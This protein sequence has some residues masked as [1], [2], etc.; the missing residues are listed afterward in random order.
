MRSNRHTFLGNWIALGEDVNDRN[1][2]YFRKRF[3][4]GKRV[5]TEK[6]TEKAELFITGMGLFTVRIN[7]EFPDDTVLNPGETQYS[8]TM[9]YRRFDVSS[10]IHKGENEI[11]VTLGNGFYNENSGV[12]NWEK[13]AWRKS[14][15]MI[16][17]LMLDDTCVLTSDLSWECTNEG[18]I[19]ENSIYLGEE[20][21]T[22]RSL[23]AAAWRTPIAVPAPD[24]RFK[25]QGEPFIRRTHA[26]APVSKRVL[27]DGKQI[28]EAPAMMT[29]WAAIR[30]R[31]PQG[32][33]IVITYG[34]TLKKDGSVVFTGNGE[35][36]NHDWW[37]QGVLQ[38][39]RFISNG[40]ETVFE[41]MFNYKGFRYVQVENCSSEICLEDV[42]LYQVANDIPVRASFSCSD[43]MLN[44]MH[45]TMVRTLVNNFQFKPTD[46]PVW[47][48]NGWLGD[49]NCALE[50]MFF[51]FDMSRY[52]AM[53]LD[54]MKDCMEEFGSVPVMV[55]SANWSVG[56]MPVWSSLFV[57][58]AKA[59][60][61]FCGET[62]KVEELYPALKAY[63]ELN[64]REV[65]ENGWIYAKPVLSDWVSPMGDPALGIIP[66]PPEG[67]KVLA[68]AYVYALLQA[69]AEI[70]GELK[71]N[72]E[73]SLF[74]NE[75]DAGRDE[76]D[77][78]QHERGIDQ[79]K[80]DIDRYESAAAKIRTAFNERFLN[81][82]KGIYETGEFDET[83]ERS[84]YRQTSNLVP[85]AFGLVPEEEKEKVMAHLTEDIIRRGYHLDTGCIGT[86]FLLP[87]LFDNGFADIAYRLL[88]QTTYPSWGYM[89]SDPGDACWETW[90]PTTRSRNHYFLGSYDESFFTHLAGIREVKNG[91]TECVIKPE[92]DCG[93]Q[94][95]KAEIALKTGKLAVSWKK[96]ESGTEVEVTVPEG[97]KAVLKVSGR[98]VVL[99]GDG[100][101]RCFTF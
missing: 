7:G 70:A 53:F 2:V 75:K 48:K 78:V 27:A 98:E 76:N 69:M 41:P 5:E 18:P 86:K 63:A 83:S 64:I 24:V 3:T 51:N 65:R 26:C 19:R 52:F 8:K 1:A 61:D 32:E 10:L 12:W 89:L 80:D 4:I 16:C 73:K 85:L 99:A 101:T 39:D 46:T 13:A 6:Q 77:N 100:S 38:Q 33:R 21:D 22:R 54:I 72:C 62:E 50:T 9:L 93:L 14:P 58:G 88:T 28:F 20:W 82:E 40:T 45:E 74:Q 15:R 81:K 57:F 25:I 11:L 94:N 91:F 49:A 84:R 30:F 67:S 43:E 35:G 97:M 23:D 95:V 68:T 92:I 96:G 29:G 34:E 37:P 90:E 60:L 71:D 44:H 17:D 59:L 87:V 55:P 36:E 79:Y 66:D 42:T 56:N 47:E 31:A